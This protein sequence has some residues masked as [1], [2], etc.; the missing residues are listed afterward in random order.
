MKN[1]NQSKNITEYFADESIFTNNVSKNNIPFLNGIDVIYWINLDESV[2]RKN[3]M[4]KMFEDPVFNNIKKERVKA[5]YGKKVHLPDLIEVENKDSQISPSEYGCLLSHMNSIR[6]LANSKY[7]VGLIMEDDCTLEFKKYWNKTIIDIINEAPSDWGIIQ[8]YYGASMGNP[9]LNWNT[10]TNYQAYN[11]DLYG[12]VA[13]LINKNAAK[14]FINKYYKNG[15][16]NLDYFDYYVSD[17][18]I[19]QRMKTYAYKYP[20]FIYRTNNDSTLHPE[21]VNFHDVT[22]NI[23]IQSYIN[24]NNTVPKNIFQSWHTKNLPLNMKK[25]VDELKKNN[26]DFEYYLYDENECRNLIKNNFNEDVLYAYDNLVPTAYK[27]DLWRYCALYSYG[28]IY[29]DI[30]FKPINNFSFNEL[31]TKE[32]FILERPFDESTKKLSF[33]EEID[34]INNPSYYNEINNYTDKKIWE[35]N[36]IGICNGLIICKRYNPILLGCIKKIVENVKNKEYG[37]SPIYIT[38]PGLLGYQ[39]FNDNYSKI[40]EIELFYSIN[41]KDIIYKNN[42]I[43][44]FYPE[45]RNEQKIHGKQWNYWE[46]WSNKINIFK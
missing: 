20:Y 35:N 39:Y 19:F 16:Y 38:G 29:L 41:G 40:K 4:L 42:V 43:L 7:N 5:V 15:K 17:K 14:E 21:H 6:E 11:E 22:K 28:G 31:I 36:K 25:T 26:P 12:A 44:S 34:M 27:V 10:E 9:V 13:Y 33:N 24:K 37:Y 32:H 23:F 8:L 3:N 46:N 1:I 2:D 45:Y 30:K 18:F